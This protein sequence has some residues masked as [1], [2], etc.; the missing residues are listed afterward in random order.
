MTEGKRQAYRRAPGI[1]IINGDDFR[2]PGC[3]IG[4]WYIGGVSDHITACLFEVWQLC[5]DAC[6]GSAAGQVD[7]SIWDRKSGC[8]V[9]TKG[10]GAGN[11]SIKE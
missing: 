2:A 5:T 3:D 6:A 4:K 8:R 7:V 11:G 9:L 10:Q 1:I